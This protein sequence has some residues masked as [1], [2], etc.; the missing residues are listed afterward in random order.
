MGVR[1]SLPVRDRFYVMIGYIKSCYDELKN[2]VSW[3]TLTQLQASSL[4]V[5]V[6][7]VFIA[8]IIYVM[9]TSSKKLIDLFFSIF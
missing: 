1:L 2:K 5:A 3:P 4:V 9:D 8:I 7:S 6:C